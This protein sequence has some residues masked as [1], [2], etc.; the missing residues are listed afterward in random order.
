MI[1][2]V[3]WCCALSSMFNIRHSLFELQQLLEYEEIIVRL[4]SAVMIV[5]SFSFRVIRC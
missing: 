5:F 3:H 4:Q 2:E 1:Q